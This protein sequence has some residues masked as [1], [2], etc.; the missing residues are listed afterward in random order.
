VLSSVTGQEGYGA[1]T[2]DAD[3]ETV[4]GLSERRFHNEFFALFQTGHPIQSAAA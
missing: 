3:P 2:D 4:R 1:I